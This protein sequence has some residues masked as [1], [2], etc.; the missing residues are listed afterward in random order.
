MI[1]GEAKIDLAQYNK[2]KRLKPWIEPHKSMKDMKGM[3]GSKTRE[4]Q[5]LFWKVHW[6][7]KGDIWGHL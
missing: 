1:V 5:R 2:I 4:W 3:K 6:K 7:I